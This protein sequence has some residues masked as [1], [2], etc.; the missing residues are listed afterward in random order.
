M[1]SGESTNRHLAFAS[2]GSARL[3]L[4]CLTVLRQQIIHQPGEH[5]IGGFLLFG[6]RVIAKQLTSH[7]VPAGLHHGQPAWL[8]SLSKHRTNRFP[9]LIR[10]KVPIATTHFLG[11]V[12]GPF[13]DNPLIDPFCRAIGC[14]GMAENMPS[15]KLLL[16]PG[17]SAFEM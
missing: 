5:V 1:R 4:R 9:L 12:T 2:F 16:A 14:K 3:L 15:A 17:H 10:K 11:L 6:R 7:T 8:L 13:V